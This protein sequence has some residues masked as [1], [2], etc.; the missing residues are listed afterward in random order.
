MH[1]F[2]KSAGFPDYL[3]EKGAIALLEQEVA[4][5]ENLYEELNIETGTALREYRLM[6]NGAVGICT[7]FL[8]PE[9]HD[10]VLAY[11]FPFCE[12]FDTESTADCILEPHTYTETYS[13]I[14][15]DLAPG[16]SLIFHMS[17][18]L[19]FKRKILA[20]TDPLRSFRGTHLSAFAVEGKVLLPVVKPEDL[21]PT[22]IMDNTYMEEDEQ[23]FL[24]ERMQTED[25]YSVVDQTFIP[26][27]VEC[28]QYSI[29]GEITEVGELINNLTG[30]PLWLL[31]VNCNDVNF[32]L[33]MRKDDLLGEPLAG[34]RIKCGIWLS[35]HVNLEDV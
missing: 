15:D 28:D 26:W 3:D 6:L 35:G 24:L 7:G 33:C 34:R 14:I 31:K 8:I 1:R 17:N 25:L 21:P 4:R 27:G 10:P 18:S 32:R 2:L 20:G 12:T 13:G 23:I 22:P 30:I 5:P 29:V 16:I 11:Y 19:D 9:H